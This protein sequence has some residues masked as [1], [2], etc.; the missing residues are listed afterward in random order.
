MQIKINVDSQNLTLSTNSIVCGT[1]N[2]VECAFTFSADWA[3]LDKWALFKIGQN[4][5]EMY[6][7]NNK[8]IIPTQCIAK[9]GEVIMSVVGRSDGKNITA[10]AEDKLLVIAGRAFDG[11]DENRL[12]TT[13]L[14][15][16]LGLVQN[17]RGQVVDSGDVSATQAAQAAASAKAAESSAQRSERAAAGVQTIN[18]QLDRAETLATQTQQNADAAK[19]AAA[20]AQTAVTDPVLAAAGVTIK[21]G[22]FCYVYYKE[23]GK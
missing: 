19:E 5:Y 11:E 7:E 10:T 14:E 8:C 21:D 3:A 17:I 22:K 9:Q 18:A 2:F 15:E 1:N 6:L 20:Q 4:T 13:Y 12:T 23:A 16:T